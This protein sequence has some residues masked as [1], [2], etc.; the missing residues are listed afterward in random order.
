MVPQTNCILFCT[1]SSNVFRV[2]CASERGRETA[3]V[4]RNA[5]DKEKKKKT[6][7]AGGTGRPALPGVA[8]LRST[9]VCMCSVVSLSRY[10]YTLFCHEMMWTLLT[11]VSSFAERWSLDQTLR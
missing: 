4:K 2:L 11:V 10:K 9:P 6:Q 7:E 3:Y 1:P 5:I 8:H